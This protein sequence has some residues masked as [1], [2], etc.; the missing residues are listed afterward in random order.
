MTANPCTCGSGKSD[1]ACCGPILAGAPA[2]TA[3]ALMRSRYSAYVRGEIDYLEHSL[4][5]EARGDFDRAV[6]TQASASTQWLGLTIR[7]THDGG[8]AD[9]TGTVEFVVRFSDGGKKGAHHELSRFRRE[10]GRWVYID[11]TIDPVPTPRTVTHVGRNDPC[12]CG[13]GKKYKK[14]CGA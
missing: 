14:C 2:P 12:P 1:D 7:S 9:E 4:A 5:P 3:E 11:G 10:A 6:A 13:S 8:P